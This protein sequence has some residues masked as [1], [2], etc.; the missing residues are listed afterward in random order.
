[1]CGKVFCFLSFFSLSVLVSAGTP[2]AIEAIQQARQKLMSLESSL[3]QR[4]ADLNARENLIS[5]SLTAS[6]NE[7]TELQ[8]ERQVLNEEKEKLENEK[9][10]LSARELLL[11]EREAAYPKMQ[12][13]LQT[14]THSYEKRLKSLER[15]RS[16]Y[17]Y[18]FFAALGFGAYKI[19]ESS[20]K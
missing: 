13:Q 19:V 18:G 1:M 16:F 9:N 2:E 20:L 12:E 11:K 10:D 5:E 15:S 17:K 3:Q 8:K 6:E 14:L 7:K 4:E